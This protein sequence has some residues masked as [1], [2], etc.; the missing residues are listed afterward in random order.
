[1]VTLRKAKQE[2]G[3]DPAAAKSLHGQIEI[4]PGLNP[5]K[6]WGILDFYHLLLS[7]VVQIAVQFGGQF[8]VRESVIVKEPLLKICL[9]LCLRIKRFGDNLLL[10][11]IARRVVAV[12]TPVLLT[13][14]A[15]LELALSAQYA[16]ISPKESSQNVQIGI[17][18]RKRRTCILRFSQ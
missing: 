1:M 11:G 8:V 18:Q 9:S 15:P 10:E 5:A 3:S 17:A 12:H 14:P 2:F 13:H 16:T 4:V 6:S 7:L